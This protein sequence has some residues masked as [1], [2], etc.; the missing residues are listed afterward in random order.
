M[1]KLS[2]EMKLS[3]KLD[4]RMIQSLKLLP[5]TIMQLEQRINE[6]LETNPLL[7]VEEVPI[8]E[9]EIVKPVFEN[10]KNDNTPPEKGN[11][12]TEAEWTKYLQDD[13]NDY[14]S[15]DEYDPNKEEF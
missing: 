9:Q 5:L 4:F 13:Y 10:Q 6:E 12:F 11:D 14:N 2:Q 8:T 1:L 15:H 7:Q 3:Q